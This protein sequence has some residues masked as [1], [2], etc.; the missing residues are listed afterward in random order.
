MRDQCR[1]HLRDLEEGGTRGL[2]FDV[3]LADRAIKFFPAVLRLNGGQFEGQPFKLEPSQ[4]FIVGSLFGWVRADGTRRFRLAYIEAGKGCGKS[5]M[6]AGIGIYGLVADNESRA[7]VYA[8][9]PLA[10]DTMVPTPDG[11]TT[12]GE[13]KVGDKVFD[14][15]GKPCKVTYLSPILYD[16]ECFEIEFSDG[17]KVVSDAN[18][19]WLTEDTRGQKPGMY[20][21]TVVTTAEIAETLRTV[22]GHVRHRIPVAPALKTKTAKLPIDPYTLGVWLGD[23]ASDHGAICFHK[24]DRTHITAIESAGY[25]VTE[26]KP[27]NNTRY[28]TVRGLRT[29]LGKLGLLNDK[30]VPEIYLRAS[31]GQRLALL[32]GLMD[33]DGGCGKSGECRFSN[34]NKRLA[35]AV[36]ELVVGLGIRASMHPVYVEYKGERRE[37]FAVSF[38]APKSMPVFLL[39]RKRERQIDRVSTHATHRYIEHVRP[40]ESVPVRCIEVNSP[41]HLYLI[42]RA[43]IATHNTKKDQAMILFRDAVSMV[44]QSP[45]LTK[46][47]KMS[48]RDDK[49]W[50]IFDGL[51]GSFFRPISSDDGQSGPRPHIGLIDELHEHRTPMVMNMMLAGRKWRRQ[52]LIIA[53]TN[54]GFDRHSVCWEYRQKGIKVASGAEPDDTYFPYICSLDEGDK[55]FEDEHCWIKA[56]PLLGQTIT[57]DYL[58]DVIM[59][60]RGMPSVESTV[61]RLNF[62]QWTE[63]S[64]P[65]ISY[66]VW[67]DSE[68]SFK[69][70]RFKGMDAIGAFDLSSTTDLTAF[71]LAFLKDKIIYLLPMFW[72]PADN[73][74]K[75]EQRDGVPYQAWV[76]DGHILTTPGPAIDKDFVVQNIAK[77]LKDNQITLTKAPYDRW[78]IDTMQAALSRFGLSWPLEPFGQ[79]FA[80]MSS[81]L[82]SLEVAILEG[83]LK[84]PGNPVMD[85]NA[86]NAVVTSDAAGNRKLDKA[87]ATGRI[88][89]I[90][91]ACMAV[92]TLMANKP[93]EKPEYKM[94]FV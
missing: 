30:H 54:S 27:Q 19:R 92:G 64:N 3:E 70:D 69:I 77:I 84:H 63:S 14:Q 28:V 59:Q 76:R 23:G 68:Q 67:K 73:L 38:K 44:Q 48:G 75:R 21:S 31:M 60:A 6:V 61:L 46:R 72:I 33:T 17:T 85:W 71:V 10:L 29:Q 52:P 22:T 43:H 62:C 88:D 87:K 2:S 47:L 57:K 32:R 26:M 36:Y 65:F 1:R 50:N 20:P 80:S 91:A 11:W 45:A 82:D 74:A 83:S 49:I 24:D 37:Y 89:G 78:R 41:D 25:I 53:I 5:P 9:A 18:H 12:Q 55:P 56:N 13:L 94:F 34:K 79:G 81:A 58:R 39:E 8:A 15:N 90:V 51:T 16:R 4:A 35:E 40:C 42:T 66:Q 7:E 93:E 86:A